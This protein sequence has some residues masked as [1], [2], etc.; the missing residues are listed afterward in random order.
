M[1]FL[2][3]KTDFALK[4]VFGSAESKDLLIGFLNSVVEFDN[5]QT[6]TD[7]TNVDPY[8]IPLLKGM[9]DTYADVKAELSDNTRVI[10]EIQVLNHEGLEKRILYNAAKIY[11]IQLRKGD[12]CHLLNPVIAL[13][14]TNFTFLKILI[15]NWKKLLI[16]LTK[17]ILAKKNWISSIKRK[18]GFIFKKAQSSLLQKQV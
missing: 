9:K 8:S 3:I 5:Q 4:K 12:A 17:L 10:I 11:S 18:I 16:S 6:I 14:I 13:T 2:D 15:E 7:L 1:K